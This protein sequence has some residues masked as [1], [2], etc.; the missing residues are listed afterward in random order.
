MSI[1]QYATKGYY[2]QDIKIVFTLLSEKFLLKDPLVTSG[3]ANYFIFKLRH[4]LQ[5]FG[6]KQ[7]EKKR[8]KINKNNY[9]T[10]SVQQNTIFT[11]SGHRFGLKYVAE[12]CVNLYYFVLNEI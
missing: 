8:T 12:K 10:I 7:N 1:Q 6:C 4:L 3:Q 5:H 11:L 2:Y 9:F